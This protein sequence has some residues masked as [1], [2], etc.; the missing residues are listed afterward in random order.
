MM[1]YEFSA[2][3]NNGVI[4]IPDEYKNK[5]SQRLKVILLSEDIAEHPRNFPL[6]DAPLHVENFKRYSRE[7]LYE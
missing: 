2:A 6:M 3:V 7:E 1:A 4:Q 5:V